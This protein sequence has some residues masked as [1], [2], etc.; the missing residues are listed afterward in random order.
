MTGLSKKEVIKLKNR[1]YKNKI[2][3][4]EGKSI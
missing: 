3:F 2:L 1:L 4:L